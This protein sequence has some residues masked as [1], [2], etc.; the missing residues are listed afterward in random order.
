[1]LLTIAWMYCFG[2]ATRAGT[3]SSYVCMSLDDTLF[4]VSAVKGHA[5]VLLFCACAE[6]LLEVLGLLHVCWLSV[7][8]LLHRCWRVVSWGL[9]NDL[10]RQLVG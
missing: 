9:P 3:Q 5:H 2:H 10:R 8:L 1:M 4:A 7:V 6:R